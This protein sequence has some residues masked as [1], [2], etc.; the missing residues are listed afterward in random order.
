MDPIE[1]GGSTWQ[2]R[3]D[4]TLYW[5]E[6]HTLIVADPHFGKAEYFRRSGIP[7]PA[8][9]TRHNLERL[10]VALRETSAQRLIVLGDFFH[11]RQGVTEALLGQ[12]R[13]WRSRWDG[14]SM[15]NLRGNHDRQ[16][17]DPPADLEIRCEAGPWR[18]QLLP[19]IAFAH[20]PCVCS[21]AVTWCGHIH[22][23]VQLEGLGK[24]RI[25][26]PCFFLEKRSATMPAFGAFTG[27]KVLRPKPGDRVFAIGP[28]VVL[29]VTPPP[30]MKAPAR[31]NERV[32]PSA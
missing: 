26:A 1:W 12:L 6:R 13:Q 2:L 29:E 8:G 20:E 17:G 14:L 31:T 25:K 4:R 21:N 9:T 10:D 32:F 22:P 16:A 28:G 11:S 23:A 15:I 18:D 5:P 27:T 24:T 30:G 7:V 19:N 3:A